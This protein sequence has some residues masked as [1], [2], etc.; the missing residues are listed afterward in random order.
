MDSGD[1][2][3]IIDTPR[4]SRNKFA[5]DSKQK[6]YELKSVLPNGAVFPF[7]FGSIPGTKA[8]D[9]DPLDALVLMDEAAFCGCL[10]RA[11]LLGVIEAE[12]EEAEGEMIRNDRL[13]AVAA[14]SRAHAGLQKLDDLDQN[15]LKEIEHF[16]VSYNEIKGKKFRPLRRAGVNQAVKLVKK[17][18][19]P[20]GKKGD[21]KADP[22]ATRKS[23]K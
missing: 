2:N 6:V 8:E 13:I 22:V 14:K 1:L 17:A 5:F 4:G 20:G 21:A 23:K 9:G 15:L 16:F 11:R 3:V 18:T 19:R 12:Q 10:V 7:D